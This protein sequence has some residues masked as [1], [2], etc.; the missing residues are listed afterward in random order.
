MQSPPVST[1]R[2]GTILPEC[3]DE[4]TNIIKEYKTNNVNWT[5][6]CGDIANSG[7][8]EHFSW[9]ELNGNFQDGN[10]HNPWGI[11]RSSLTTGLEATRSNFGAPIYLSSGYRCPH[12]N[13]SVGGAAQSFHVHGRA[14]DMYDNAQFQWTLERC[15]VVRRAAQETGTVELLSCDHYAD[16]HLH[17][18]W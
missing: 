13:A 6:S 15:E 11:V 2:S 5:P 4:R 17:A 18:A 7:G 16:R 9:S 14:A 1:E 3:G 12:G 10:P 8:S